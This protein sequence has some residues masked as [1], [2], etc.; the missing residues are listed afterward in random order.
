MTKW[1][2][3]VLCGYW[4]LSLFLMCL[5]L[6]GC[7][8]AKEPSKVSTNRPPIADVLER[9]SSTLMKFEGVLGT[10]EGR[11]ATGDPCIKVMVIA[12][13]EELRSQLPNNLEG[14]E[15]V[16]H[17]TGEVKPVDGD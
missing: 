7:R 16:L 4:L 14:Y 9:H 13:T 6:P 15:V 3:R 5:A 12:D 8:P 1:H 2:T 10:Y 17:E 11:S